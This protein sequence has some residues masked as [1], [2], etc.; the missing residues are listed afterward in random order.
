MKNDIRLWL[1]TGA[2]DYVLAETRARQEER[3]LTPDEREAGQ[4]VI[5]LF[6]FKSLHLCNKEK[7]NQEGNIITIY[8]KRSGWEKINLFR[9]Q[10]ACLK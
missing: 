4:M 10:K 2:S 8:K 6:L 1:T 5:F 3:I 7:K 9:E